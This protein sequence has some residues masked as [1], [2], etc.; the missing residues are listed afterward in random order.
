MER[1]THGCC[2]RLD[3][4]WDVGGRHE[5]IPEVAS[6]CIEHGR[7]DALLTRDTAHNLGDEQIGSFR[8]NQLTFGMKFVQWKGKKQQK[9]EAGFGANAP[10]TSNYW[11]YHYGSIM[12]DV[13]YYLNP[14]N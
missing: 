12:G 10:Y 11:S 14:Q 1:I 2:E 9:F 8:F 13:N 4:E 6:L 5:R 3:G 7:V